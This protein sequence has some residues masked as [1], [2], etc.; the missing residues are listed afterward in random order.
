MHRKSIASVRVSVL[1][2]LLLISALGISA[3]RGEPTSPETRARMIKLIGQLESDPYVDNGKEIRREVMVWL[4]DAPD[5]SV[6]PCPHVIGDIKKMRDDDGALLVTQLVFSEAKFILEHPDKASDKL[7]VSLGG[8]EGVLRT[9][10]AMKKARPSL[11]V[12]EMEHLVEAQ[13]QGRLDAV[14]G[15]GLSQCK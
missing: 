3:F 8:V 2:G 10:S 12:G 5:I 1:L 15:E 14:V 7:A 9:Y 11:T 4:I 6:S 13:S